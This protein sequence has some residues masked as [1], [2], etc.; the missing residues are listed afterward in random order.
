MS[1]GLG[2]DS[3][4]YAG[5]KSFRVVENDNNLCINEGKSIPYKVTIQI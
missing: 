2:F 1:Q 4:W 5:K 3:E